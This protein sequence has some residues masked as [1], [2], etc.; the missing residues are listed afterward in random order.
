MVPE[1][2][3]WDEED[4]QR[5]DQ[6]SDVLELTAN[7]HLPFRV[8]RVMDN[9]PEETTGAQSEEKSK[10]EEPRKT[11]LMRIEDCSGAAQRQSDKGND[12]EQHRQSGE[13]AGFEIFAFW[14]LRA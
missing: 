10:R 4:R 7:N 5:R 6:H 9:R 13:A 11:E 14:C 8:G 12:P 2:E 3:D 1:Q